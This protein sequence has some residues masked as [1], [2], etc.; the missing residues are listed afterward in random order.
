MNIE[1]FNRLNT[2]RKRVTYLLKW[3]M[4][5]QQLHY[6]ISIWMKWLIWHVCEQILARLNLFITGNNNEKLSWEGLVK[7]AYLSYFT[8]DVDI[9]LSY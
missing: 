6:S 9:R 7:R 3:L 1:E 4:Q 5:V 2:Y 8:Q